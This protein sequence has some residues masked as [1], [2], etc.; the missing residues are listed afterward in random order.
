MIA[1]HRTLLAVA[2]ISLFFLPACGG[3]DTDDIGLECE[4]DDTSIDAD[5]DSA[6]GFS[7]EDVLQTITTE[8]ES[9]IDWEQGDDATF[10]WEVVD[11]EDVRF[12]EM[13]PADD[14]DDNGACTGEFL[15]IGG[16]FE[17]ETDDG[18][19][20]ETIDIDLEAESANEV[21]LDGELPVADIQGDLTV[22]QNSDDDVLL[23]KG[24]IN[25]D[26]SAGTLQRDSFEQDGDATDHATELL[27]QW[28]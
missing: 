12:A 5:D 25:A 15:L 16:S 14:S 7:A 13:V 10:N 11:G 8:G 2:C 18:E 3:E 22:D 20:A 21:D 6:L 9:T 17:V 27:G 26:G 19:L 23:F 1:H 4:V 24:G 28:E